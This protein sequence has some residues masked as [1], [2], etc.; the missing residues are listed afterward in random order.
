MNRIQTD[1]DVIAHTQHSRFFFWSS[2][3][4]FL[5]SCHCFLILSP[6]GLE[7]SCTSKRLQLLGSSLSFFSCW[8]NDASS[9]EFSLSSWK[10]QGGLCFPPPNK[11]T[12]NHITLYP[13]T[14]SLPYLITHSSIPL[15]LFF[16]LFSTCC[17]SPLTLH[18]LP[19][20]RTLATLSC[21]R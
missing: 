21:S 12:P 9:E 8:L 11:P 14:C 4:L 10:Y 13:P 6:H 17:C 5:V 16:P 20:S 18:Y 19:F 2:F 7:A 1:S 15:V 3:F